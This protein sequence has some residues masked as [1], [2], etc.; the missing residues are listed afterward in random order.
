MGSVNS[1]GALIPEAWEELLPPGTPDRDFIIAGVKDGFM[2]VDNDKISDITEVYCENYRSATGSQHR[3]LVEN[4][5]KEEIANGQYMVVG[6]DKPKIVS[7]IG[8]IPKHSANKETKKIR[9]IHDCSRPAQASLNDFATHEPF[10]YQTLQEALD[11]ISPGDYLAKIDLAGAYRS[12][13]IHP[14]CYQATGLSWT[15]SGTNKRVILIDTRLSF[16]ARK[17][18]EIFNRLSQA[19]RNILRVH[20]Y[21][22]LI[23]YLDDFL[24]VASSHAECLEAMS[25]LM[26]IL[27][28]L[29]FKINYSKVEGPTQKLCFLGIVMDTINMN[30]QLPPDKLNSFYEDLEKF[31]ARKKVTKQQIQSIVGKLNW[32][33]QCVYGG[34]FHLRRLLDKLATL[35]RPWH[36]T[37]V[38]REMR[39]DVD[40]WLTFMNTS[41]GTMPIINSR[42]GISVSIDACNTASGAYCANEWLYSPW[43]PVWPSAAPLHINFK[44]TLSLELAVRRWGHLWSGRM[45]HIHCDNMAAVSIINKGSSH[46]P[47]VM[48]SL[49]RVFM[50]STIYQFRFKAFFYKGICNKIADAVSRLHEVN[51]VDRLYGYLRQTCIL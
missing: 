7:A 14:E 47:M 28:K 51:G 49:R 26:K 8:A 16:G 20:G 40:W 24:V 13:K 17:S 5:I 23:A 19:V 10:R 43:I 37:R 1:E 25:V 11:L 21:K 45:V 34:R 42:P 32:A 46:N 38:T 29:G 36:R 41:N 2:I 27:R 31:A 9:I 33:S 18:P 15:F 3:E 44:E 22:K 50:L 48:A 4:Q 39:A 35:H 12:V 30:L 6:E